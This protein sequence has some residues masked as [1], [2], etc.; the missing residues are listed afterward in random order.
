MY[1]E[2]ISRGVVKEHES[3]MSGIIDRRIAGFKAEIAREIG[4]HI[5]A[6]GREQRWWASK[7]DINPSLLSKVMQLKLE[8]FTVDRLLKYLGA[9]RPDLLPVLK[10]KKQSEK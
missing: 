10:R 7:L 5:E 6:S 2:L 8:E 4:S 9:V 1:I 3:S